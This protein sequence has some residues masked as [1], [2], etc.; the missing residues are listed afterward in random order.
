M[1]GKAP[2][3]ES[4][5]EYTV[6]YRRPPVA[7][8]FKPGESG[9]K[10]GRPKASKSVGQIIK[11]ELARS[12]VVNEKN[13]RVRKITVEEL[14]IRNL[15]AGAARG[16]A[17]MIRILYDLKGRYQNGQ[18]THLDLDV[19]AAEDRS[20]I[21]AFFADASADQDD[22]PA[23]SKQLRSDRHEGGGND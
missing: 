9:N 3:D 6:G 19:L 11:G 1:K 15:A 4:P 2:S 5:G 17:R 10:R 14:I 22:G 20:I 16:D 23:R 18:E 8:R 13:G 12:V 7:S 21:E